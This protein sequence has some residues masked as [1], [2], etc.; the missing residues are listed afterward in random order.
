MLGESFPTR[1]PTV[2]VASTIVPM[3]GA[4]SIGSAPTTATTAAAPIL[5]LAVA[6]IYR[7]AAVL[8]ASSPTTSV[9]ID[10]QAATLAA[11]S[12]EAET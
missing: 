6:S 11:T 12:S 2:E 9:P 8:T 10:R 1:A 4:A 5:F 7:R 3:D